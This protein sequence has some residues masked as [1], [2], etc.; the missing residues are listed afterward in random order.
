MKD[1]YCPSCGVKNKQ[2][3]NF[4]PSCGTKLKQGTTSKKT[5][6][7]LAQKKSN[8]FF[9]LF[10][11]FVLS[12]VSIALVNNSNLKTYQKKLAS[13]VAQS[14][15]KQKQPEVNKI[16]Q[17]IEGLKEA[18]KEDPENYELNVKIANNFFDIGEFPKAIKY[19]QAAIKT[20]DS[21]PNV[22]I[23]LGVSYYNTNDADSA[24]EYIKAALKISP[25][26]PQ[27]LY[28]SGIVHYN[29]GDSLAAIEVWEKLIETNSNTPQAET[30]KKFIDRLKSKT[31]K[32]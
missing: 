12:I 24:L 13:K 2:D 6:N 25:N 19:Y 14:Q 16:M 9:I 8:S 28:N 30:A 20:N 22:L 3:S 10:L 11:T 23:D 26:H 18:L 7:K 15:G 27:G 17:G 21:D 1:S 5:K 32:S 29:I 31:N 4:C